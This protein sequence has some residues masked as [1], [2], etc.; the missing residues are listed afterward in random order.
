MCIH[1]MSFNFLSVQFSQIDI[2]IKF[3]NKYLFLI[4]Q[5]SLIFRTEFFVVTSYFLWPHFYVFAMSGSREEVR[6]F[7][8]DKQ[9]ADSWLLHRARF[10]RL[11]CQ[12]FYC[13]CF[14]KKNKGTHQLLKPLTPFGAIQPFRWKTN[15]LWFALLFQRAKTG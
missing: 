1:F 9:D 11:I 13:F 6:L 5:N 10:L 12:G 14:R 7:R 4:S 2:Q 3:H 8:C 15:N